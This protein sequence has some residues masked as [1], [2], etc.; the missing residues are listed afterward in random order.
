M[1]ILYERTAI[2]G[3]GQ[4]YKE[5]YRAIDINAVKEK[6]VTLCV[7]GV[8]VADLKIVKEID[9]NLKAAVQLITEPENA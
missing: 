8:V 5:V 9:F 6:I 2:H 7:T 4:V 1:Y 3:H